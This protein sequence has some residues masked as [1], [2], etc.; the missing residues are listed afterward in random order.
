MGNLEKRAVAGSGVV[1]VCPTADP[2]RNPACPSCGLDLY[3][4]AAFFTLKFGIAQAPS[5]VAL[6]YS[7]CTLSDFLILMLA[8]SLALAVSIVP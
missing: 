2:Y 6:C 8:L 7:K 5:T 3:K 4:A 1:G